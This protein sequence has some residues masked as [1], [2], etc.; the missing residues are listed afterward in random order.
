MVQG[1]GCLSYALVLLIPEAGPLASI[2]GTNHHIMEIHRQAMEKLTGAP[3]C[4]RGFTD[5]E[6]GGLKFSGNAQR[7]GRNAL[8]FHGTLLYAADLTL[9]SSVLNHPSLE[10]DWRKQRPHADFI[11]NLPGLNSE[12]GR[13][14]IIDSLRRAWNAIPSDSLKLDPQSFVTLTTRHSSKEWI[15]A[16]P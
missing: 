3:V 12:L 11:T 2:T 6:T 9:F 16:R 10:P 4:I 5:L 14:R 8:L 1:P 15:H 7:R 13:S